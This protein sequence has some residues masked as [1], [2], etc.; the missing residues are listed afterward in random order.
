MLYF[1]ASTGC[2]YTSIPP[3][4]HEDLI[5]LEQGHYA[6]KL[7]YIGHA[8]RIAFLNAEAGSIL[9]HYLKKKEKN[10]RW[11]DQYIFDIDYEPLRKYLFRIVKQSQSVKT[12]DGHFFEVSVLSGFRNR[13][14]TILRKNNVD[15][16]QFGPMRLDVKD[17][18][19]TIERL[20]KQFLKISNLLTVLKDYR[21]FNYKMW[22]RL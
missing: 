14:E 16:L 15:P 17:L 10:K 21:D 4:R 13:Y 2:S 12:I 8:G 5:E 18:D 19:S 1:L 20:F 7:Y 3:I 6:V 9:N 22:R 11:H